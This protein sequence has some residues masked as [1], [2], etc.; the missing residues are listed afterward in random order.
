MAMLIPA[1]LPAGAVV[2][3]RIVPVLVL[4][5]VSVGLFGCQPSIEVVQ[6]GSPL[7]PPTV[8]PDERGLA[9]MGVDFD[10]PLEAGQ[11]LASGGVT[12]LVAV[13]N[14]G[15]VAEP[16]ARVTARLYDP[17]T[18]RSPDL[19]SETVTARSLEPGEVRVVRFTQVTNLP[20][21]PRYKLAVEVSP[22]PGEREL[23]DNVRTYDI[24]VHPP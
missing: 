13:E 18:P 7:V 10:P 8:M 17:E 14:Q 11:I 9:I 2:L 19:A 21:R 16:T 5:L 4:A 20:V 6:P 24:I 1:L 23:S 22:V 3:R 15:R 12:L